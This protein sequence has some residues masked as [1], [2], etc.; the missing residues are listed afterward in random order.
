MPIINCY[1]CQQR[2]SDKSKY[3]PHCNTSTKKPKQQNQPGSYTKSALLKDEQVKYVAKVS[4]WSLL[5]FL[6][7]GLLLFPF[8]IIL[9]L[10]GYIFYFSTE[11]AITDKR[12]IAKYG[13]IKRKTVEL[14]IARI[15]SMQVEQGVF[16]RLF[17]FGTLTAS[18]AGTQQAPIRNISNPLAFKKKLFEIQEMKTENIS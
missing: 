17:N 6:I 4:L 12:V 15:E 11:L 3:C 7:S 14:N 1:K 18:G 8:G 9:W 10:C 13:F 2:I 5:P 16:G